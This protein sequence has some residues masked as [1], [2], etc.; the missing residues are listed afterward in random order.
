MGELEIREIC[1]DI[2]KGNT[3]IHVDCP[4]HVG[5]HVDCCVQHFRNYKN[6]DDDYE[7]V[8]YSDQLEAFKSSL[9][10]IAGPPGP[11]G[12]RGKNPIA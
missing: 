4:D 3:G 2:I 1:S 9:S 7:I 12:P 5:I 6:D 10:E 11:Q 8:F